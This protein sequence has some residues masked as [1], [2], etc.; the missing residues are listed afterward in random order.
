MLNIDT[1]YK[2]WEN[3]VS[4]EYF[5]ATP[6]I[7]NENHI[8]ELG[9]ILDTLGIDAFLIDSV[10]E[11]IK[12]H[13]KVVLITEERERKVPPG[14]ILVKNKKSGYLYV[15]LKSTYSDNPERYSLP[16]NIEKSEWESGTD[17]PEEKPEDDLVTTPR[18]E[19]SKI[20]ADMTSSDIKLQGDVEDE[21]PPLSVQE[22]MESKSIFDYGVD[23]KQ[24]QS[25]D[26][27]V[28]D[29]EFKTKR[30]KAKL[31]LPETL[32]PYK[33]PEDVVK[34]ALVPL[35]YTELVERIVN[36]YNVE[37]AAELNFY[38]N[39]LDISGDLKDQLGKLIAIINITLPDE[40]AEYFI[41][42]LKQYKEYTAQYDKTN[43]TK[44]SEDSALDVEWIKKAET[45][46]KKTLNS[47]TEKFDKDFLIIAATSSDPKDLKALNV[48]KNKD[49]NVGDANV[50][51]NVNE[52]DY[53]VRI[54]LEVPKDENDSDEDGDKEKQTETE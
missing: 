38:V 5:S 33:I 10:I 51:V 1:I 28:N 34:N 49:S 52:K 19:K 9:K 53:W 8:F 48:K 11:S 40:L 26:R 27:L 3:A 7:K 17:E 22:P 43:E 47:L 14:H 44:Y 21:E 23:K 36:T 2:M 32:D 37:E 20:K 45:T 50:K 6:N 31:E 29:N 30:K 54:K 4:K 25:K 41:E 18:V 24:F 42:D 46:R 39:D 15:I 13:D 35:I 12:N 16:T